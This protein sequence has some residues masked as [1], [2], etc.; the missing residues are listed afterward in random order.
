[1]SSNHY[2]SQMLTKLEFPRRIFENTEVSNY[3]KIRPVGTE[4]F[5]ADGQTDKTKQAVSFRNFAN[6]PNKNRL[7]LNVGRTVG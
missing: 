5:R 3:M 2:S 6:D 7:S 4:L 1:M